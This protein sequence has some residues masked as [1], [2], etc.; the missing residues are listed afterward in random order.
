MAHLVLSG[1]GSETQLIHKIGDFPQVIVTLD[2]VLQFME[3][4]PAWV[5]SAL[6][7]LK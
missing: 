5:V 4:L 3:N 6:N 7:F 2:L 1:P